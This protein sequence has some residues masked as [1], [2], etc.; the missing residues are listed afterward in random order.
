MLVCILSNAAMPATLSDAGTMIDK[1]ANETDDPGWSLNLFQ[2]DLNRQG[3]HETVLAIRTKDGG[4]LLDGQDL[5][6]WRVML[7]GAPELHLR[8]KDYFRLQRI[9]GL[10][11]VV[12]EAKQELSITLP[13]AAFKQLN[14]EHPA[15]TRT[16]SSRA[17]GAVFN[18][19]LFAQRSDQELYASGLFEFGAFTEY[20]FGG[21]TFLAANSRGRHQALRLDTTWTLD[22][23]EALA[24]WRVGD[25]ITRSASGWGRSVRFGGLQYSSNFIVQPG[26]ITMPQ[27]SIVGQASLPST[28]D[29]FVN[30]ALVQ[31]NEVPP[32][33]FSIS[34]IPVVTGSGDVRLVVRDALGRE[35]VITQPFFA[36]IRLLREGLNDV[37]Y[38]MGRQRQNYTLA[39]ND[40]DR[41]LAAATLR[42]GFTDTF[43]GEVH[44]EAMSDDQRTVGLNGVM[45]VP[46][47]AT[48]VNASIAASDGQKGGGYLA[49]IGFEMQKKRFSMAG[50]MQETTTNFSQIG[51]EPDQLPPRR[52]TE[53]SAGYSADKVGSFGLAYAKHDSRDAEKAEFISL[54]YSTNIGQK[55]FLGVSM[56]K[57]LAGASG[58][59]IN[60]FLSM[61]MGQR[62]SLASSAQRTTGTNH[63]AQINAQLQRAMSPG[64]EMGYR[65]Q[66]ANN[67]NLEAEVSGQNDVATYTAGLATQAGSTAAR[68][69]ISGGAVAFGGSVFAS[70]RI[71]DSFALVQVPGFANVRIYTDNQLAGHTD[72]DGNA[73]IP[74]IR[75]FE[76]NPISIESLNLPM[77]I[78]VGALK[79]D[80]TPP[81]RSGVLVRFPVE[82]VR[83]AMLKIL[84]ADGTAL[85]VGAQVQLDQQEEIFPVGMDGEV[86]V[87]GLMARNVLRAS[88]QGR[89]CLI[90]LGFS[91]SRDPMPFLGSFKCEGVTP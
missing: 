24:S 49:S 26:L 79:M 20:G 39:S 84:L 50:R 68:A 88:W 31:R 13:A 3:Q 52:L 89:S 7:P 69:S 90:P 82:R 1:A 57:S 60:A 44:L 42:H 25:A 56:F 37:S 91:P 58:N 76:N 9:A 75:A 43:T 87:S 66:T 35:Q 65:L 16:V 21:A 19:D 51:M 23:P 15:G 2:V 48:V 67:G 71:S 64:G 8:G 78:R 30:Q 73:L 80:V 18:Y 28:V 74:R 46:A 62:T 70:R 59:S 72:A 40:Y 77:D 85:P 86:Y 54:S 83:A 6:R 12:D 32:G 5:A 17:T 55:A 36:S 53:L 34:N 81:F 63:Y 22:L 38:E 10:D 33:P 41:W 45:A 14:L 4:I 27:Q 29:V 61:P 11:V 47:M